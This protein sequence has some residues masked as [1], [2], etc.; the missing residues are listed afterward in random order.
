M[1]MLTALSLLAAIA[2]GL[3]L[4]V[5]DYFFTRFMGNNDTDYFAATMHEIN[6]V[7]M[8]LAT[9]AKSKAANAA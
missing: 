8:P 9:N 3:A 5:F 4:F 6:T 1:T 2:F 7:D